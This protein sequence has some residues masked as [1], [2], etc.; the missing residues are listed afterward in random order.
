M[1]YSYGEHETLELLE[2]TTLKSNSLIKAKAM[3]LLVSDEDLKSIL[4]QE[5]DLGTRQL[6]QL[7]TLIEKKIESGGIH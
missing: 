4:R 7:S 3:Q 1:T 5:V 2:M 6:Q